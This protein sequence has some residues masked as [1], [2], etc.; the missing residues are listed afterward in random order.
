MSGNRK[1][2]FGFWHFN[3]S[4]YYCCRTKVVCPKSELVWISALYCTTLLLSHVIILKR[5][6]WTLLILIDTTFLRENYICVLRLPPTVTTTPKSGKSLY[7]GKVIVPRVQSSAN[8]FFNVC[9]H[10]HLKYICIT[11]HISTTK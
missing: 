4:N 1:K 11:F 7:R 3:Y 8:F 2:L 6:Y 9:T 5:Y 10:V